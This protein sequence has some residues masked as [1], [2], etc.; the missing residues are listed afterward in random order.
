MTPG[1]GYGPSKLNNFAWK[2]SF[3]EWAHLNLNKKI[4]INLRMKVASFELKAK[5]CQKVR[6]LRCLPSLVCKICKKKSY[7][8]YLAF[9]NM[10]FICLFLQTYNFLVY[11]LYDKK[12]YC[13]F[14]YY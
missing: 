10:L 12:W 14:F 13:I 1:K 11:Y 6:G 5:N 4:R 9:T 7:L 8:A 2:K 3:F